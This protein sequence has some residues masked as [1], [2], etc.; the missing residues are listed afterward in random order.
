MPGSSRISSSSGFGLGGFLLIAKMPAS[1]HIVGAWWIGHVLKTLLR[2]ICNRKTLRRTAWT[3]L[4]RFATQ[5]RDRLVR[6]S[7]GFRLTDTGPTRQ[8]TG[9]LKTFLAV[10]RSRNC[11]IRIVIYDR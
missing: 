9:P 10:A 8:P 3:T 1:R 6:W 4:D 2:K 5:P 11:L 7:Q